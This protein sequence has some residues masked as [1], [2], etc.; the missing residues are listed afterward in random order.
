MRKA[1][2]IFLTICLLTLT[3]TACSSKEASDEELVEKSINHFLHTFNQGGAD[4]MLNCFSS[5]EKERIKDTLL[6]GAADAAW[7]AIGIALGVE[8]IGDT[9]EATSITVSVYQKDRASAYAQLK[10]TGSGGNYFGQVQFSLVKEKGSW[11]VE[12]YEPAE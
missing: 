8:E 3:L 1:I 4:D 10:Y 5:A 7:L 6:S 11:Y 9:V 12:N 2:S